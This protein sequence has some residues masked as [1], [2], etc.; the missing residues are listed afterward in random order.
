MRDS[1][2]SQAGEIDRRRSERWHASCRAFVRRKSGLEEQVF[3]YDISSEGCRFKSRWP[4]YS[5]ELVELILPN[6]EPWPAAIVWTDAN[7]RGLHF[8]RSLPVAVAEMFERASQPKHRA[9][10]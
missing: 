7:E 3:I 5:G 1:A 9:R 4:I 10:P 2:N 6:L 8:S